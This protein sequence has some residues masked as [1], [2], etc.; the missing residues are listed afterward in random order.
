MDPIDEEMKTRIIH[1]YMEISEAFD[2]ASKGVRLINSTTMPE[3]TP[4]TWA[5]ITQCFEDW[6]M[7]YDYFKTA[8]T[9]AAQ[10][11]D[12]QSLMDAITPHVEAG[13]ERRLEQ[14]GDE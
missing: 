14:L 5:R 8:M 7:L 3:M 12:D 9:G 1:K 11:L 13:I 6:E 10:V 4:E 2:H